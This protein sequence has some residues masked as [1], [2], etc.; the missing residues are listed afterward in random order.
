MDIMMMEQ[1]KADEHKYDGEEDEV[2][3][4]TRPSFP[5]SSN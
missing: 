4:D 3:Y 2:V 1:A 5:W